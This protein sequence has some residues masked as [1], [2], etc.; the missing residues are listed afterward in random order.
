M[1][2]EAVASILV[3]FSEQNTLGKVDITCSVGLQDAG[4]VAVDELW[5][6][7][8]RIQDADQVESCGKTI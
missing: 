5:H 1:G 6:Q 3:G 8:S 7:F 2:M 4:Q